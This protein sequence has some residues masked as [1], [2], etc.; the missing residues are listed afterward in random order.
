MCLLIYY[1]AQTPAIL[2]S[3]WSKKVQL[4]PI[5]IGTKGTKQAR[6]KWK[7]THTTQ[8]GISYPSKSLG[9]EL[10]L[11]EKRG[12]TKTT[13]KKNPYNLDIHT[14]PVQQIPH[15][16]TKIFCTFWVALHIE[17]DKPLNLFSNNPIT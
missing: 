2:G 10:G 15:L 9:K 4:N 14:K 5:T 12:K 13:R 8:K 17:L 7:H 3:P 1:K 11:Q 6:Q 16:A